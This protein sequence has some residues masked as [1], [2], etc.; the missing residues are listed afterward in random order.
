[1]TTS[2]GRTGENAAFD[3]VFQL[4]YAECASS[5]FRDNKGRSARPGNLLDCRTDFV[6]KFGAILGLSFSFTLP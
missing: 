5:F 6:R 3:D 4:D 1:V 2:E